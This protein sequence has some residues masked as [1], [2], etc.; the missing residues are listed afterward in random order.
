MRIVIC[1]KGR[2]FLLLVISV[3]LCAPGLSYG[4][5]WTPSRGEGDYSVVFQD[6]YTR[7]HLL[8]DGSRIDAGHVTLLGAVQSLDFGVTDRLA[9]TL[10]LPFGAGKYSGHSPHQFPID[11]G[12]YHGSLQDM[13]IGIRYNWLARPVILTPFVLVSFPMSHYEHFAH[14]AIGSDSWE[15]RVGVN[16]GHHFES[17]LPRAY[18]QLQ[19]SYAVAESFM[20]IR[21]DR[22]R[23]NG[24]FGYFLTKRLSVRALALSQLTHGG[25][26]VSDFHHRV[27]T[28]P[29]WRQH[30]RIQRV[31]F[32]NLG[33]GVAYSL[34]RNLDVFG[35]LLHTMWGING[36]A[37][38]TG[39]TVG[40][41]FSFRTPWAR[42]QM[43]YQDTAVSQTWE[44]QVKQPPQIQCAH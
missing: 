24:E 44:A 22:N 14:S 33:G 17:V 29:L 30:D 39:L 36:H 27:A 26:D 25:L 15:F 5:A 12:N 16:A 3:C 6:L 38:Y 31:N 35:S 2:A 1:S 7:D 40:L 23:F 9:A 37:L 8:Q 11:D 28:D 32:F 43:A 18:Y 21:P 13:G 42:P 41:T 4:Q 20:N 10:A 34:T 19:Y